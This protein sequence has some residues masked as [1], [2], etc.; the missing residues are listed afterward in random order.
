MRNALIV[1][2]LA[3]GL[4]ACDM[5]LGPGTGQYQG[6]YSY[7]GSV[8]G[9]SRYHVT[10]TLRIEQF[11]YDEL[12]VSI[13]WRYMEGSR[14]VLR[15]RSDQPAR[16][17]VSHDGW[18]SFEFVG[19]IRTSDGRWV[20]F[21]LFHEGRI[22]GRTITGDWVLWTDVGWRGTEDWGRFTARR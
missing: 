21:E 19:D 2:L 18:I 4:T 10:G 7:S 1:P 3:V 22:R 16:A 9:T 17:Y 13:D 14:Q 6:R 15:I 12:L 11:H 20:P 8:D 5:A